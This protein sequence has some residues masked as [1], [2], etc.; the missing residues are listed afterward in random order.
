M[1]EASHEPKRT[2]ESPQN[3]EGEQCERI[4]ARLRNDE[5]G[6]GLRTDK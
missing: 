3:V 5:R 4:G 1:P 6:E 2:Y